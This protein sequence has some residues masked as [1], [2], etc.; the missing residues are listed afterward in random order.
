MRIQC[1]RPFSVDLR[2]VVAFSN[3]FQMEHVA[4]PRCYSTPLGLPMIATSFIIQQWGIQDFP[5]GALTFI[6]SKFSENCINWAERGVYPKLV[7]VDP[8]LLRSTSCLRRSLSKT[9]Q[10][11]T[12]QP[13][14]YI[15]FLFTSPTH[16]LV[17]GHICSY[18]ACC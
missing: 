4:D 5:K 7:Y 2:D 11:Q 14:T 8:P 1:K 18:T 16:I 3:G 10:K 15:I 13:F 12:T 9:H 6:W 17:S